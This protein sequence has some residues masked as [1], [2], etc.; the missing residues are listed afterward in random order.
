MITTDQANAGIEACLSMEKGI[1]SLIKSA[2][3]IVQQLQSEDLPVPAEELLAS[4]YVLAQ[5][6][7]ATLKTQRTQAKYLRLVLQGYLDPL[8]SDEFGFQ[9]DT[10]S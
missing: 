3:K 10:S 6:T 4:T 1:D 2:D 9:Q 8:P 5:L 7:Q